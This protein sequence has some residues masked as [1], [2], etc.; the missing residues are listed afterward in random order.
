MGTNRNKTIAAKNMHLLIPVAVL[1]SLLA[2]EIEAIMLVSKYNNL[3]F[4]L[5]P[6]KY[7]TFSYSVCVI[8]AFLYIRDR[9][10]YKPKLLATIGNYSFGI[11]LI[12]LPYLFLP[13]TIPIYCRDTYS[14]N[15][16]CHY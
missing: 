10:S 1:I 4:A 7:S 8:V 6:V 9:F 12:H 14:T 13:A 15:M 3:G 16:P 2:S 5:S 11:Y